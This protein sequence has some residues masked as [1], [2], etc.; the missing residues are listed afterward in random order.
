MLPLRSAGLGLAAAAWD[1][2]ADAAAAEAPV[3]AAA[4]GP[5]AAD[6]EGPLELPHAARIAPIAPGASPSAR[7]RVTN[8]RRDICPAR[9]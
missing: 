6:D 1:A 7:R 2:V 9:Y 4:D 8:V 5:V 3:D